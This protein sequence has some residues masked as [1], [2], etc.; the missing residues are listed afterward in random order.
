MKNENN[1]DGK[2]VLAVVFPRKLVHSG[3][4]KL[5]HHLLFGIVLIVVNGI[6]GKPKSCLVF[7]KFVAKNVEQISI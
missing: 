2:N 1:A 3:I 7:Q 6:Y 4:K 5:I